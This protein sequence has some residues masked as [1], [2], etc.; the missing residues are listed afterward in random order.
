MRRG[1]RQGRRQGFFNLAASLLGG[2]KFG[3]S[4]GVLAVR[5]GVR[6]E[7]GVRVLC[8]SQSKPPSLRRID[9]RLE[10]GCG[11]VNPHKAG[12]AGQPRQAEPVRQIRLRGGGGRPVLTHDV[13]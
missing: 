4:R 6:G 9:S 10:V 2:H 1:P 5:V 8:P 13:V 3:I 11:A 12:G 7:V